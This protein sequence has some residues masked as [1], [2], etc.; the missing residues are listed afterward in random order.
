VRDRRA[1]YGRTLALLRRG[2]EAAAHPVTKSSIMLGLGET[3]DE[4]EA[5]FSDLREAGVDL[6]TLGQYLRPSR[7]HRAVDRYVPPDG[8]DRL[9]T[10]ALA[11]GFAGVEAGPLVRSS[12]RAEALYRAARPSPG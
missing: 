11:F 8:F 12:Y 6:L 1:S 5:A 2:H 10:R 7:A 4:L 9:R 3:D